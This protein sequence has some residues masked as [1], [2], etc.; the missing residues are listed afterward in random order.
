MLSLAFP[1]ET[2][3]ILLVGRGTKLTRRHAKLM[4]A[5]AAQV[6]VFCDDPE[7]LP[8]E[9]TLPYTE[10]LPTEADVLAA[11]LVMVVDLPEAATEFLVGVCTEQRVLINVEDVKRHCDFYFMSEVRRGDL[12][13]GISSGGKAPA[14]TVRIRKWLEQQFD[15]QWEEIL[16]QAAELRGRLQ[17]EGMTSEDIIDHM[18][19]WLSEQQL[20]LGGA[21]C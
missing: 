3:P 10:G 5:G 16:A 20:L 11:R 12:L 18:D 9:T 19:S 7:S 15:T 14:L 13:I 8:P 6:R 2:V 4:D 17:K 21:A 1:L